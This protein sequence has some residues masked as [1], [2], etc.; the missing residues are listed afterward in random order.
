MKESSWTCAFISLFKNH[1]IPDIKPEDCTK[2]MTPYGMTLSWN[3]PAPMH[4]RNMMFRV[5]LKDNLKVKF[6]QRI[7]GAHTLHSIYVIR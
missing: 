1:F 3:L 5:H 7:Q 4:K 6:E 2:V